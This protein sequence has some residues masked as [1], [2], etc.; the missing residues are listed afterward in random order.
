MEAPAPAPGGALPRELVAEMAKHGLTEADQRL[1]FAEGFTTVERFKGLG[2]DDYPPGIDIGARREAKRQLDQAA[3]QAQHDEKVQAAR[4]RNIAACLE[5]M[6]QALTQAQLD[7][8]APVAAI[9]QRAP[10]MDALRRLVE[11]RGALDAIGIGAYDRVQLQN[12]CRGPGLRL[13]VREAVPKREAVGKALTEPERHATSCAMVFA[14]SI[15]RSTP[16]SRCW[17]VRKRGARSATARRSDSSPPC[18]GDGRAWRPDAFDWPF[19]HD[20]T[21]N[22]ERE[23]DQK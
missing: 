21:P 6:R 15:L 18:R 1:L 14:E 9:L 12:F 10:N 16:C 7:D 22:V 8:N 11:D 19:G 5:K 20:S 3:L 17:H 13:V 23:I 4:D 2:D